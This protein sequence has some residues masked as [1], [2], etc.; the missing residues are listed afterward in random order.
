LR[1]NVLVRDSVQVLVNVRPQANDPPAIKW[2]T[3]WIFP[4]M[5]ADRAQVWVT[6]AHSGTELVRASCL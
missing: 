5:P 1:V 3:S 2:A 6:E 4:A